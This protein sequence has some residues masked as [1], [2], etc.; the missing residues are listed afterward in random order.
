MGL[1]KKIAL[2][3]GGFGIAATI[4]AAYIPVA[5]VHDEHT[6]N[7]CAGAK[8]NLTYKAHLLGSDD[9]S[10]R[11]EHSSFPKPGYF[12]LALVKRGN[13]YDIPTEGNETLAALLVKGSATQT[14]WK[15][16]G[17]SLYN[18]WKAG[19]SVSELKEKATVA[20][21][22]GETCYKAVSSRVNDIAAHPKQY[23]K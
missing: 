22:Q 6:F 19:A 1:G 14:S 5:T 4:A 16:A 3:L 18:K 13:Q 9:I 10:V 15:D 8:T 2:V 21:A 17:K 23:M 11:V 20:L 7:E 12:D